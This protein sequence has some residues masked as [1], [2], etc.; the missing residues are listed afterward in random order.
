MTG[1]EMDFK[2]IKNHICIMKVFLLRTYLNFVNN[3]HLLAVL[4]VLSCSDHGKVALSILQVCRVVKLNT[5]HIS[6]KAEIVL[7]TERAS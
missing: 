6:F 5:V 4:Y 1:H 7:S 3:P 2:N